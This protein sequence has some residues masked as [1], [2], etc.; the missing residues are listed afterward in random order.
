VRKVSGELLTAANQFLESAAPAS[1]TPPPAQGHT[2]F[3]FL[4]FDGIRSYTAPEEE[5]G[6]ERDQLSLVFHAA[7]SVIAELR[8]SA[9]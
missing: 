5:L 6:Y 3:Y 4:T 9:P 8:V 7:H 1:S 2:T